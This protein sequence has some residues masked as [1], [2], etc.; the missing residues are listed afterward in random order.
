MI[1]YGFA[2]KTIGVYGANLTAITLARAT[3][4]NML[5]VCRHNLRALETMLRYCAE[6]RI[7][8]M[9]ISS[10]IIP[11]ASHPQNSFDWRQQ[12]QAELAS[13]RATLA[14][15]SCGKCWTLPHGALRRRDFWTITPI[16]R[17]KRFMESEC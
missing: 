13:A 17:A 15:K 11:L 3:P 2:C 8:L 16:N 5:G 9:R 1:R 6:A 4:E 10:D 7:P 14:S 12:L